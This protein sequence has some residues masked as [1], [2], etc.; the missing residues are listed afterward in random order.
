MQAEVQF[1][2]VTDSAVQRWNKP[3]RLDF[4]HRLPAMPIADTELLHLSHYCP[5]VIRLTDQ[6]PR[7][8]ILL[9]RDMLAAEPVDK[10][11]R[12]RPGYSPIALRTLPFWP[13]EEPAEIHVAPEL[14]A[15]SAEDGF[16]LCDRS[17]KPS[18]QFATMIA[19]IDRLRL[20]MQ[21]LDEAA[22]L[23]F[24][25]DLLAPLVIEQP[26]EAPVETG[27]FSASVERFRALTAQQVAVLS[28]DRCLALDLAVA[29]IFSRRLVARH[30]VLRAEKIIDGEVIEGTGGQWNDLVEPFA[31]NLKLD[32]SQLF[33]FEQF[34]RTEKAAPAGARIHAGD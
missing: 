27:Y 20:G 12:W 2:R 17:G 18:E 21:R 24:A 23:L 31:M 5:V 29:C 34:R 19:S 8:R 14:F 30:V 4:L 33:S 7:V 13:G 6:G 3:A 11:G 32:A 1:L 10:Q 25:V 16:P 28:I 22:K 15:D 26:G 9:D